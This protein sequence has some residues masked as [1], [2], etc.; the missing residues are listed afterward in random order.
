M[1]LF[2]SC[3]S[4]SVVSIFWDSIESFVFCS[5]SQLQEERNDIYL[6]FFECVGA[7]SSEQIREGESFLKFKVR[8]SV[9]IYHFFDI[10]HKH[11]CKNPILYLQFG[12]P[13]VFNSKLQIYSRIY[14]LHTIFFFKSIFVFCLKDVKTPLSNF[15]Q[16]FDFR[17]SSMLLFRNIPPSETFTC[18]GV[19]SLVDRRV[20]SWLSPIH[21]TASHQC[22]Y[23]IPYCICKC[24]PEDEPKR[25]ETCRRQQKLNINLENC[26][27]RWFVLYK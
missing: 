8:R 4:A 6:L 5:K 18:I 13:S 22:M 10:E 25:L 14:T 19:N 11:Y 24:L 21:Q 7:D 16:K 12:H 15:P 23:N 1:P 20:C 9:S 17:V 26:A 27:F 3:F 2:C